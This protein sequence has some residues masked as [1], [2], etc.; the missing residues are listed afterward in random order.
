MARTR[1]NVAALYAALDSSREA[2]QQS[3]RQL[4]KSIGVSPSLLFR[5]GNGLRPDADS[6][7]TLTTWLRVP[8]ETFMVEEQSEGVKQP[9]DDTGPELMTQLAPLLR[10]RKDLNE[11]DVRYLE[12]VIHATLRRTRAMRQGNDADTDEQGRRQTPRG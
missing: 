3:W 5:L 2:R 7:A 10:A 8:A 6:F 1:I 12:D 11:E 9:G 4:A